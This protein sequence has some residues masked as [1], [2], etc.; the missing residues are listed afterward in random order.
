[1]QGNC[2]RLQAESAAGRSGCEHIFMDA[3]NRMQPWNIRMSDCLTIR[4]EGQT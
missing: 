4:M 1:M 2:K 3:T